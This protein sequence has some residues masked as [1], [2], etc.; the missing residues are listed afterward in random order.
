MLR[1]LYTD[2]MENANIH[3]KE[4]LRAANKYNIPR[5]KLLAEEALCQNLSDETVL[6]VAKY[7]YVHN[8]NNAKDFAISCI[9]TN[10]A[11][12]IRRPEWPKFVEDN[13][14]LLNEIHLRIASK[15]ESNQRP[16]RRQLSH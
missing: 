16:S 5:M 3:A 15:L 11:S 14:E 6:D 2:K 4:L 9:V 10:F 12:L 13:L 8:G 1:F 7:A